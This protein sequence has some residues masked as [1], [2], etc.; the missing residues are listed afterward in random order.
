MR[1]L[2]DER[3]TLERLLPGLGR[4]LAGPELAELER[5]GGPALRAFRQARGAGLL[6]P[7]LHGG[8]GAGAAD[9]LRC[10]LAIGAVA[11]SLAIATTT[12]HFSV[13]G[14]AA[15]ARRGEDF[16][17]LLLDAVVR[18]R[19]LLAGAF[20]GGPGGPGPLTPAMRAERAPDGGWLVSGAKRPCAL[21]RSADVLVAG[22]RLVE[23]GREIGSGVAL[24]P[25]GSEG[26]SV[27][28]CRNAPVLTAA[29]GD[30]LVLENVRVDD[31][32]VIGVAPERGAAEEDRPRAFGPL[33]C[34]LLLSGAALGVV[35]GLV[36]RV[37]TSGR[38][39]ARER[40][41][42]VA[43]VEA[44]VR[45][46][47]RVAGWVDAGASGSPTRAAAL[48]ARHTTR[49]AVRRAA[50]QAVGLLGGPASLEGGDVGYLARACHALAF[51]PTS[52]GSTAE[53]LDACLGGAGLAVG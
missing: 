23:R 32:L 35:S 36:E 4:R 46:L 19:L 37:L 42:L 22:V 30:E 15:L 11:P 49:A 53:P 51:P 5:P 48:M 38:G 24:A 1:F 41:E 12:H 33:W 17:W 20:A 16:A 6:A 27:R 3:E 21:S 9:A 52:R 13:A 40:G 43:D 50:G 39:T 31:Q 47:D 2:S 28:P 44:A 29:E 8:A 45:A 25:S 26:V 10:T 7:A 34:A 14:L 18:D